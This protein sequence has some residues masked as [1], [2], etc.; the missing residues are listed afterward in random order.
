MIRIDQVR[1]GATVILN[2]EGTIS[3]AW[4]RE[5]ERYWIESRKL[6]GNLRVDV[7]LSGVTFIDDDGRLVLKRMLDGGAILRSAGVMNRAIIEELARE[8]NPNGGN[9]EEDHSSSGY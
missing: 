8:Q 3:G 6:T 1:S 4:A 5:L 7:D 2:V 9:A